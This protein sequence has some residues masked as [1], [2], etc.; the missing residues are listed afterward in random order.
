MKHVPPVPS[1]PRALSPEG[2]AAA[3]ADLLRQATQAS[4]DPDAVLE[5]AVR[6]CTRVLG[7]RAGVWTLP[8]DQDTLKPGP[9]AHAREQAAGSAG[10]APSVPRLDGALAEHAI[11]R[12]AAV[13]D[14]GRMVAPLRSR[15]RVLG[16][17]AVEHED[18]RRAFR[19]EDLALLGEV[20]ARVGLVLDNAR[21]YERVRVQ[22]TTLE[23]VDAAVCA[24]D[25]EGAITSF[26]P[27]AERMFGY[28]E[29]EVLGRSP[30]EL[31]SAEP[32]ER[33][34]EAFDAV[35]ADGRHAS[36]WRLR[37]KGGEP[38]DGHIHTVAV[39]DEDG[40][41]KG[42]VAVYQD[43][44]ERLA[45]IAALERKA[46]QQA[47]VAALGER[48]LEAEHPSALADRAVEM[49]RQTLQVELVA[50]FELVDEGRMLALGAGAGFPDNYV[51]HATVPAGWADGQEGFTLIRREP[52]IVDDA[53]RE[54]RFVQAALVGDLGAISGVSVVVGGHGRTH[55]VLAAYASRPGAFTPDDVT[56]LQS[57]A[58]VLGDAL[59]RFA[60]EEEIR[61]R[62]LHDPLT[63]LPNRALVL[64]RLAEAVAR[65]DPERGP[66]RGRVALLFLDLDHFKL[67]NDSLGHRAG[68]DVLCQV[69]DRLRAAVRPVDTVGRFGGD[70][71]VVLCEDVADE[72]MA[73]AIAGR[74]AAAFARPFR[75]GGDDH[76]LGASIGVALMDTGHDAILDPDAL[77]RDADAAM[78]R[79]KEAGR[80]R[81]EVFDMGMRAWAVDRLATE[82]ALRR[83]LEADD[84]LV[85]RYQPVV[86]LRDGS[87][88]AVE[89]LVRWQHPERGLL[90]PD[91]F[92]GVAEDSGL[93]V[94]LGRRVLELACAQG[95]AWS[96]AR[97]PDRPV[98]PV[99]VNLSPRQLLDQ[100]LVETVQA[101]LGDAP[102]GALT[103][104][105]TEGTL[106]DRGVDRVA[107]LERLRDLGVALVLDDFGTG[108]SS[109]ARL[110]EL[111]IGGLKV[112]RSFVADIAHRGGPIVEAVVRLA[113]AFDLPVVAEGIETTDQLSALADLDCGL[114]QGFLF[115][116]ALLAAELTPLLVA[117]APAYG[118]IVSRPSR[119]AAADRA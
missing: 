15:G 2:R 93:I 32:P 29:A 14:G 95:A 10:S 43:L 3:L 89:A 18:P 45:L 7:D 17:L 46:A 80:S 106:I 1:T 98:L 30:L 54:R 108:W 38:F 74:L 9:H 116:P 85:V 82:T 52:V 83:A 109:L 86:D 62:G 57:M 100:T 65:V 58:N 99:H 48:A 115:A 92:V 101:A 87:I 91:A 4:L 53:R 69:A 16:V 78:Y 50:L 13:A 81:I 8:H 36:P 21:L 31:F 56:F 22:A 105:I 112:D 71:F 68:D 88:A 59:D 63:E 23:H 90:G 51:G 103:L 49:V 25:G 39:E 118:A 64:E 55:A 27:A 47:A 6:W 26:N 60:G 28:A 84:E 35:V 114:G 19:R 70:E 102:P 72:A 40:G 117:D 76:V 97:G 42:M 77:L 94:P 107:L 73:R 61:H 110:A 41:M 104:E 12:H 75:A 67:V 37:R 11:E 79:A 20:A 24:V 111:P 96:A 66:E 34:A 113:R 119:S 44:S 5:V 33:V